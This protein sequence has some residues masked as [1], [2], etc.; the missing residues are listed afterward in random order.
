M[1]SGQGA[2]TYLGYMAQRAL[3]MDPIGPQ[4]QLEAPDSSQHVQR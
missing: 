2:G 1:S 4:A 3:F